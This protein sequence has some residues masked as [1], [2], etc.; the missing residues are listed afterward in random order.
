MA[1]AVAGGMPKLR[2]EECAAKR[3]AKIDSQNGQCKTLSI[4]E[5]IMYTVLFILYF[6]LYF[7][8]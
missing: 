8:T 3:Q 2:I 7:L 1:S 5:E 4:L 6:R